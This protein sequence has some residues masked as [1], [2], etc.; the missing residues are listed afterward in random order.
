ME[1][2]T[3]EKAVARP[4]VL[5]SPP[6]T[7]RNVRT[8]RTSCRDPDLRR[9]DR[10]AH[11]SGAAWFDRCMLF[12]WPVALIRNPAGDIAEKFAENK[13]PP[14]PWWSLPIAARSSKSWNLAHARV[15]VRLGALQTAV[16]VR[17]ASHAR[18]EPQKAPS[19]AASTP[20]HQCSDHCLVGRRQPPEGRGR[21]MKTGRRRGR[22]GTF[23][24]TD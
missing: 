17:A 22:L 21:V 10:P 4:L 1:A 14:W 15:D 23:S 8:V 12:L 9:R 20:T 6:I 19:T 3:E 7:V 16:P 18:S 11:W 5:I 13:S 2:Q 24:Q